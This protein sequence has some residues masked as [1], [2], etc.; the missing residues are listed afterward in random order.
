[1]KS[2][3]KTSEFWMSASAL[4]GMMVLAGIAMYQQNA[5][6]AAIITA[7]GASLAT[8]GYSMSRAKVKEAASALPDED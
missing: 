2:G 5:D 6:T 7:L 8:V 1:M 3:F 4:V